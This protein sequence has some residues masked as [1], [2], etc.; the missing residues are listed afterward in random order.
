MKQGGSRIDLLSGMDEM[1][2]KTSARE[3]QNTGMRVLWFRPGGVK[4]ADAVLCETADGPERACAIF[5][6]RSANPGC[7]ACCQ[8]LRFPRHLKP[9]CSK[10]PASA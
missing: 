4:F 2:R 1:L 7:R 9:A 5:S 10:R 8:S 3:S 6:F